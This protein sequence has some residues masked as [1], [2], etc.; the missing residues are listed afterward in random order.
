MIYVNTFCDTA[1]MDTMADRLRRARAKAGFKSALSAARKHGWT[2]STYGAHENG[3]NEYDHKAAKA[4]AKAFRTTAAWLMTGEGPDHAN[5][6]VP[7]MGRIG[8]GA[9]IMPEFEQLPPEGL[10]EIDAMIPLPEGAIAFEVEG[11]SMWPRYDE[12]DVVICWQ[13]GSD[14][15]GLLGHEAAVRTAD[16]KRYLKRV[17]RGAAKGTFDLES[18]NAEPIRGV[19]LEWVSAV[20]HVI[21]SGKW[22]KLSDN[23]RRKMVKKAMA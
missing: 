17:L 23:E 5:S 22:R 12:G 19:K 2:P 10:Y 3:Q 11:N 8:A 9:E 7:V 1:A 15:E 20:E 6:Q 4:Y 16:G 18:H 13:T 21:R 14:I